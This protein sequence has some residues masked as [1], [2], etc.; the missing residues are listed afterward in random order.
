M[1]VSKDATLEILKK[2]QEQHD[3]LYVFPGKNE[4]LTRSFLELIQKCDADYVAFSDQDD[5]WLENKIE[6]AVERLEALD[7]PALYCSNQILVDQDLNRLP[8]GEIPDAVP[9]FGNALIESMCTGCT[10]VMNRALIDEVKGHLPKNAIWHDWWCYLVASYL[11]TVIFDKGAYILYRQHGDNQLGSSRSALVMIKNKW[12]FL[13]KTRG[14]L[15]KQIANFAKE[16]HGNKEK[17]EL[18]QLLLASKT[19]FAARIRLIFNK[20]IYRQKRL[21][22]IVVKGLYLINRML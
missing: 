18:V 5:Y 1:T 6:V 15:G 20:K 11:G 2:Y 4:G 9:G 17:D 13:K 8:E 21:D 22:N 7:G 14:M 16:Y 12:K 19:S 10:A 3:N